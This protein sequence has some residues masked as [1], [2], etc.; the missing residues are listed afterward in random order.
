MDLPARSFQR[1]NIMARAVFIKLKMQK[2]KLVN[3]NEIMAVKR[4]VEA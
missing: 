4:E 1:S 3:K 2:K